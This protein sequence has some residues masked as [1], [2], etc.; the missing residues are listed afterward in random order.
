MK[1]TLKVVESSDPSG[2][3]GWVVTLK[4]AA[5]VPPTATFGVPVSRR[6]PFPV[7]SIVNVLTI[8]PDEAG[9]NPK[10][11]WSKSE[12]VES[13]FVM[14][15][16]LPFTSIS[17]ANKMPASEPTM[18]DGILKTGKAIAVERQNSREKAHETDF[19]IRSISGSTLNCKM[20]QNNPIHLCGA[21]IGVDKPLFL[22]AG[23]CVIESEQLALD[24]AGILKE[25]KL[26]I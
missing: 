2:D 14:L 18:F 24:T 3:V 11:V 22:I 1:V 12:G 5:F 6:T 26:N 23:P 19:F 15:C 21:P 13:P 8:V 16:P 4:S 25:I 9:T 10:R 7:L 17:R 20:I